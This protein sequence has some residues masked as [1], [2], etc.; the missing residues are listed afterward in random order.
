MDLYVHTTHFRSACGVAGLD[1]REARTPRGPRLVA[2]M[3]PENCGGNAIHVSASDQHSCVVTD[4]GD[5]YTWGTA[6][7]EGGALGHGDNRWQ[8]VAKRVSSLKKVSYQFTA[9]IQM[10][11]AVSSTGSSVYQVVDLMHCTCVVFFVNRRHSSR[12]RFP[13]CVGGGSSQP[14]HGAP[15]GVLPSSPTR[16]LFS[17]Y[18]LATKCCASQR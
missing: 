11:K 5:L 6:G 13:G 10:W 17:H 15:A 3:L 14:Y 2:A 4:T 16:C 12:L 9:S 1:P 7:E 8:P 18:L